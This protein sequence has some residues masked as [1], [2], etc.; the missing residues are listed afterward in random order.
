MAKGSVTVRWSRTG[1]AVLAHRGPQGER[2]TVF[3]PAGSTLGVIEAARI[4]GTY[5]LKLY[6]WRRAGRLKMVR[7]AGHWRVPLSEVRRL[8][9]RGDHA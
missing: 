6:R 5:D 8:M 1:G 4:L 7:R 2:F 9:Q 3:R